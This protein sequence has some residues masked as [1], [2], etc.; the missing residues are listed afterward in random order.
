MSDLRPPLT[1]TTSLKPAASVLAVAVVTLVL[2][3]GINIITSRTTPTTTTPA[4]VVGAL[5]LD[6][7]NTVAHACVSND[8][9]PRDIATSLIVPVRTSAL[10]GVQLVNQGAGDFD[11]FRQLQTVTTQADLLG[12]YQ[13]QLESRGWKLYSSAA[14]AGSGHGAQLLFE[15]DGSDTFLWVLGITVSRQDH[16]TVSYRLRIYQANNGV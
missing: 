14:S 6:A 15:H 5:G 3:T 13:A 10:G 12:F 16:H 2:F 9:P 7:T 4:I 11:C 1:T 8:T